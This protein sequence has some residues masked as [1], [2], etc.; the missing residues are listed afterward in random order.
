MIFDLFITLLYFCL[1]L[2]E[3][4]RKRNIDFYVQKTL[5]HVV[6][7]WNE[8]LDLF[9]KT[10][11]NFLFFFFSIADAQCTKLIEKLLIIWENYRIDNISLQL[12]QR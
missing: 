10:E 5:K 12:I 4:T 6:K 11:D 2:Y 7:F 3:F 9:L 8:G 1:N